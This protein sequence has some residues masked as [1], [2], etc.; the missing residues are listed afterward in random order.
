MMPIWKDFNNEDK[1]RIFRDANRQAGFAASIFT[2]SKDRFRVKVW[3]KWAVNPERTQWNLSDLAD[4][5]SQD[6]EDLVNMKEILSSPKFID[7]DY[8]S[9]L[10]VAKKLESEHWFQKSSDVIEFL[11]YP[12]K[13]VDKIKKFVNGALQEYEDEWNDKSEVTEETKA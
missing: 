1:A 12:D 2:Y 9:I 11:S 7:C 8:E 13:E 4:K 6:V 3:D 10:L 5:L